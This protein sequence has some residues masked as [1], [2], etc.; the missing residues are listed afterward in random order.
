MK[1]LKKTSLVLLLL[2][3]VACGG[4]KEIDKKKLAEVYVD[5]QLT[6]ELYSFDPDTLLVKQDSVLN[7]YSISR[8]EFNNAIENIPMASAE[9]DTFFNHAQLYLDTLRARNVK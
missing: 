6:Q 8:T 5:L 9:W 7:F 4:D 2:L 3:I 1:H